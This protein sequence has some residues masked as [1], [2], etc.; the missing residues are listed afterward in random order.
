M[1]LTSI[2]AGENIL[3]KDKLASFPQ[4]FPVSQ[5]IF[6]RAIKGNLGEGGLKGVCHRDFADIQL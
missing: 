4:P 5:D 3:T 6:L 2:S 1:L